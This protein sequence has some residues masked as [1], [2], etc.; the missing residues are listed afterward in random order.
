MLLLLHRRRGWIGGWFHEAFGIDNAYTWRAAML[1][2]AVM[3]FPLLVRAVRLA[4]ELV[5]AK[6]EQAAKTLGAAPLR[7]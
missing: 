7:S 4:I 5:D 3:G 2:A 6:L 1:A